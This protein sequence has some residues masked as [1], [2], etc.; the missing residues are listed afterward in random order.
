MAGFRDLFI[1]TF[2]KFGSFIPS[3]WLLKISAQNLIIPFYHLASN[4]KVTHIH[5]LYSAKSE[6]EFIYDMDF[7]LKSY[8]PLD[9]IKFQELALNKKPPSRP[10]FLLTF[11]DGLKQFHDVIAPILIQKGIPSICFLNS[12]FIDNQDLFYRYKT[13][14]L[15]DHLE[16]N[17][18]LLTDHKIIKWVSSHANGKKE[19]TKY[20]LS[21][22][23][24][25]KNILDDFAVLVNYNFKEY[26][27]NY[28]PYLTSA[29]IISLKN[30][31]FHFGAHSID[32]PEYQLIEFDEQIRQTKESIESICA[33]FSLDYKAFSFPFTDYYVSNKFFKK[34]YNDHIADLTFASA[35]QKKEVYSRHFQRIAFEMGKLTAE[36]IHNSE[37]LY[38]I[39]KAFFGKN[40][41]TRK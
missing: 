3:N 37:L 10:S 20:L 24:Q 38:F 15:I 16:N 36:E 19:V 14:L 2:Y 13:S 41:I 7:L 29:Q 4:E 27:S 39:F 25:N 32:H 5:H 23:Y 18:K 6:K 8:E 12:A 28:Q 26:L 40:T 17:P 1:N 22:T 35:G 9:Y 33:L 11:D 31:G 30:K 21:I 34:V